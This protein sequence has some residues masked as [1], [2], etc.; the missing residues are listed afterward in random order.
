[1]VGMGL[2][3]ICWIPRIFIMLVWCSLHMLKTPETKLSYSWD[4]LPLRHIFARTFLS[5][6]ETCMYIIFLNFALHLNFDLDFDHTPQ[7]NYE[8]NR[9][10]VR[11]PIKYP[12]QSPTYTPLPRPLYCRLTFGRLLSKSAYKV[13][14]LWD[15]YVLYKQDIRFAS[16]DLTLFKQVITLKWLMR[17]ESFY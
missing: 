14:F 7:T 15:K 3:Q 6:L 1:M 17:S 9:Y 11:L 10:K 12:F 8:V 2:Q 4:L 5:Q 13:G 16:H